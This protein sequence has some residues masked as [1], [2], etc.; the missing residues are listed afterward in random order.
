MLVIWHYRNSRSAAVAAAAGADVAVLFVGSDQ[1]TEAEN[2]DRS[3]ITLAGQQEKLIQAVF[4]VQ[5][6]T[7]VVFISGGIV[8]SPWTVA[9]VPAVVKSFYPGQLGGDAIVDVLT[10]RFTPS[11]ALPVTM[12][13]PNITRRDSRDV[14]L[15]SSGGIT[16]LYFKG[17]VL[18]PYGY[19]QSY[20]TFVHSWLRSTVTGPTA[21]TVARSSKGAVVGPTAD[22]D[23]D[24]TRAWSVEIMGAPSS[25][26]SSNGGVASHP[27]LR[28]T[29]SAG[30]SDAVSIDDATVTL[31]L[32]TVNAGSVAGD[33]PVLLFAVNNG[34]DTSGQQQRL[35]TF[36][37]LSALTPSEARVHDLN[38][39]LSD[40]LALFREYEEEDAPAVLA[41]VCA[42]AD[43][44]GARV[45]V[46]TPRVLR[47]GAGVHTL[48]GVDSSSS[49]RDP[50]VL[51]TLFL[52]VELVVQC[53]AH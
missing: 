25:S 50:T 2:F 3:S 24:P 53:P 12:Y 52:G 19:S 6:R 5:P 31:S 40:I 27:L 41:R 48:P 4:A 28:L 46:E 30:L 26:S 16:H 23:A 45:T 21:G 15:N 11:G 42:G 35:L 37:R 10:G 36:S 8:S 39:R 43:H 38:I 7:V 32:K 1:T 22:T 14:N 47:V 13:Y 33:C 34:A 44:S 18:F 20:T 51:P 29:R 17:P 49:R 9:N